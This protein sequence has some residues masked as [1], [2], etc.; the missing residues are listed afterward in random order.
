MPLDLSDIDTDEESSDKIL[1]FGISPDCSLEN[2]RAKPGDR[3]LTSPQDAPAWLK[4]YTGHLTGDIET[5]GGMDYVTE[6]PSLLAPKG[7]SGMLKPVAE[8]QLSQEGDS[9]QL[10]PPTKELTIMEIEALASQSPVHMAGAILTSMSGKTPLQGES[11][12]EVHMQPPYSDLSRDAT[13][14]DTGQAFSE[15]FG[16][17]PLPTFTDDPLLN[18]ELSL[19]LGM[20]INS[21]N[22]DA[23]VWADVFNQDM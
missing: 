12:Q 19:F 9:R 16:H 6:G 13:A 5:I 21:V 15:F 18:S 3:Q 4:A 1:H 17:G 7:D 8:G 23:D 11:L 2:P 10:P 14:I 22:G 20:G